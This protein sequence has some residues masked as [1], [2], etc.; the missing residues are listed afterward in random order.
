M[1]EEK[2]EIKGIYKWQ[3]DLEREE[4]DKAIVGSVIAHIGAAIDAG[5]VALIN[6]NINNE[7]IKIIGIAIFGV[8]G[9]K[10]LIGGAACSLKAL[11]HAIS[12]QGYKEQCR[13]K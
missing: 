12:I 2:Y 9:F 11:G 3:I 6:N 8:R 1:K 4:R 7:I 10:N 13:I 5:L